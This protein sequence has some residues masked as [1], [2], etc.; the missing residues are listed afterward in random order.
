MK[1]V[2]FL[3]LMAFSS[4]VRAN[5][6]SPY[7]P[8]NLAPEV[9]LQIEKLMAMTGNTP[10][11]RPYK[12]TEL[13]V[14]L[15]TIKDYH[16]VLYNRLSA[17]L[18]RYTKPIANTHRAVTLSVSDDNPRSLENNRGV[19]H[20]T[21]FEVS[22]A[23]HVFYNPYIYLAAGAS[24]NDES[25]KAATNTHLSM[26]NEYLQMDLGF[27]DH[28]LSPMQ[29]S[30]MLLSTH[31]E[32]PLSVT[33]SNT[34]GLTDLNIRYELFYAK[35]DEETPVLSNGVLSPGKPELTGLHISL[36]PLERFSLGFTS[37]YYFG[38]GLRDNNLSIGLK[39]LLSPSSVENNT[40]DNNEQGYGQTAISAKWNIGLEVPFSVYTELAQY[41]RD[42]LGSA[43]DNGQAISAGFY[44]PVL[45]ETMSLRYELTSR[46][47]GWYESSF[48]PEGMRNKQV[49]MGHWSADEFASGLSPEALTHHV[50]M[51]WEIQDDQQ[52]A[53]KL[54]HQSIEDTAGLSD[55]FQMYARYSIA[56][57]YGFF[58]VDGTIGRDAFGDNY[59][60]LSAF[61]RW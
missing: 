4:L 38:G 47:D 57:Q 40:E 56:T 14:R 43:D 32:N 51:D 41:Q 35:F 29:D 19:K 36:S 37:T 34:T 48:Y 45:F 18:D 49:L 5:G 13:V 23:G 31:A 8:I 2:I 20:T 24:Y 15:E 30:A 54:T 42:S 11:T 61:Y 58:G 12:A 21:A 59:N 26:G 52:L 10:L 33:F 6:V 27:R 7:L 50:M 46:D 25:G 1:R 28:W 3:L 39:G 60:R 44:A 55:T 16:P 22:A 53:I 9:E 17:Y